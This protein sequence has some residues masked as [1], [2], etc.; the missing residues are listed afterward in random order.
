M[1]PLINFPASGEPLPRTGGRYYH[2]LTTNFPASGEHHL[3]EFLSLYRFV[4]RFIQLISP[5]SGD[6][7]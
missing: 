1:L 6:G 5:A 2:S 3:H 7:M 4:V